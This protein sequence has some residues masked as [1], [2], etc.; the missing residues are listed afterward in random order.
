MKKNTRNV[1][2][3][4][5]PKCKTANLRSSR[6]CK[7]CGLSLSRSLKDK[8]GKV[9]AK[10][11]KLSL[12]TSVSLVLAAL[13][14]S[15][16]GFM[17]FRGNS[18][19]NPTISSLPQVS[20][21]MNYSGQVIKMTKVEATVKN[22]RISIEFDAVLD[23]KIVRFDYDNN[24][25]KLPLL[26][27]ITPSGKAVTAVSMCE[28]CRSTRFHIRGNSMICNAC[29]TEWNLET[30]RGIK[31]GCLIYPPDLIPNT[32]ENRRIWIDEQVIRRWRPRI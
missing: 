9:L 28:P 23:K 5:C 15:W 6:F 17:W 24:G 1:Q 14:L 27:Y 2:R 29:D 3:T 19:E 16:I 4:I 32:I 7:K 13:F 31:G 22:G 25:F 26:A 12:K 18:G 20:D 8:R 30:L 10:K 11:K 21:R